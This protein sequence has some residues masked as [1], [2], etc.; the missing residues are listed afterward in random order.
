MSIPRT[1]NAVVLRLVDYSDTSQI[2]TFWTREAGRLTG[3][4][5][6]AK[7]A[8]T[9]FHGPFDLFSLYHLVYREKPA[10]QLHLLTSADLL[11]AH[12]GLRADPDRLTAASACAEILLGLTADAMPI[13]LLFDLLAETLRGL[14]DPARDRRD[15]GLAAP[16]T[17]PP[18]AAGR[19]PTSAPPP[20]E[21]GVAPWESI[22]FRF[23]AQTLTHL[24]HRPRLDACVACEEP[25]ERTALYSP[26]SGGALCDR[27]GRE[28]SAPLRVRAESLRVL[29]ALAIPGT[30]VP[31]APF[32]PPVRHE[33]RAILRNAY[34][35]LLERPP[36]ALGLLP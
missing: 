14:E 24:G 26:R 3:I 32:P 30:P 11:D 6:G 27:C 20:P 8:K 21:A 7:R 19:Q 16:A 4:A 29:D 18:L 15:G 10:G 35:F 36:A 22:L 28:E 13:P 2:V 9:S 17:P 33:L 1:A 12:A 23:M 34:T 25:I 5:K 31:A